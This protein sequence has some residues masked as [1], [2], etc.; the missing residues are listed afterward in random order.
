[1]QRNGLDYDEELEVFIEWDEEFKDN[2][3]DNEIIKE[4]DKHF[5]LNIVKLI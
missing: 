3:K 1:M 2:Y 5:I 4:E